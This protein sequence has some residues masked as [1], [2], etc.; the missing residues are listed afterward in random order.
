MSYIVKDRLCIIYVYSFLFLNSSIIEAWK[1]KFL[2]YNYRRITGEVR[3]G[4]AKV[5]SKK[6]RRIMNKL[7][8]KCVAFAHR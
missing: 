5:N 6:I 4:S 8:L 3:K 2:T 1:L 7:G